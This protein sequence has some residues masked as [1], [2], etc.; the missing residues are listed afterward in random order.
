VDTSADTSYLAPEKPIIDYQ[1]QRYRVLKQLALT[2]AIKFCGKWL[3]DKFGQ[4]G[5]GMSLSDTSHLQEIFATSAGLKALTTYLAWQ[6]IEDCRKCCGGNGYLLSSGVAQSSCDYVWQTTAE[7]DWIILMLQTARFLQKTLDD[8]RKG[9]VPS[10]P[11][12]Y[13]IPTKDKNFKLESVAP[14][15]IQSVKEV[16][17]LSWLLKLYH[18]RAL[19]QVATV[20]DRYNQRIKTGERKDD[21]WNQCAEELVNSVRSHSLAF[22]LENFIHTINDCKD[23]KN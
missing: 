15:P 8:A 11:C 1:V 17:N 10:G 9:E 3:T 7:G 16:Y 23:E 14:Q 2:Y 21:A 22:I 18:Y 13:M 6:G 5:E 4:L 20:G 12:S 19:V